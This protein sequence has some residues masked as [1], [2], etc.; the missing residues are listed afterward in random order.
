MTVCSGREITKRKKVQGIYIILVL[1]KNRK[2]F[3]GGGA[4]KSEM[5]DTTKTTANDFI[6][7]LSK[8]GF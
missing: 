5:A 6:V 3:L 1:Y 8:Q 4:R 2:K 7:T